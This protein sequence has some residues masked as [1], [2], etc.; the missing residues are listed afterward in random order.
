[1][2]QPPPRKGAYN[3]FVQNL[4]KDQFSKL[5]AKNQQE[6]DLLD[7]IRN[8]MKQRAAIEKLYA[9]GLIKLSSH[10]GS[11]KI[12]NLED[13]RVEGEAASPGEHNVYVIWKRMLEENE[14][15]AKARLAAIQVFQENISSDA[16]S[17]TTKK[18]SN[19]KKALDRLSAIQAEVQISISEVDRTKR[20]YFSEESDAIDMSKKAEDAELKAKGKKRDVMSIFQS[21]TTLKSKALK[22]SAKQDESDIKST[23]ARNDYLLAV[24]TANAHQD[25]YFHYDLQMTMRDMEYGIYEKMSEYFG[26]IARTELLTCTALQNS[27]NKLKDNAETMTRDYNYKC[28]TK[29]YGCLADHVQ[30][31]FESVEGDTIDHI[32]PSEHDD[33]YSLKYEA[34][35][36]AAKLNQAVKTIRA[37]RKR[38][39]ACEHHKAAGLLKEPNDANGPGLDDKIDELHAAIRAAETDLAKAKVR[40]K[41]LREGGVE[42]DS[43]LGDINLDTVQFDIEAEDKPKV[44]TTWDSSRTESQAETP[45]VSEDQNN[46]A[47]A[48]TEAGG[49]WATDGGWGEDAAPEEA[50][51]AQEDWAQAGGWEGQ[52]QQEGQWNGESAAL[53]SWGQ[54]QSVETVQEVAEAEAQPQAEIDPNADIWKAQVLFTF[55]SQNDD[56]LTVTE[57]EDVEILVRE[58]DEEGWVMARNVSGQKGYVPSNY[59]EVY[60]SVPKEETAQQYQPSYA[61]TEYTSYSRQGSLSSSG[62]VVKQVSVESTSSWGMPAPPAGMPPIP[63]TYGGQTETEA[64]ETEAETEDD[65][66]PPG[67]CTYLT[68]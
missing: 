61:A 22:L 52:Q 8:F 1:M 19:S 63:E 33:G 18:K 51:E 20:I 45:A 57:N 9:D 54:Q 62:Q 35:T 6:L 12:A 21:R 25:R 58:C 4:H 43:Y 16:K 47:A 11:K 42:V 40:L 48:P 55:T 66:M 49:D 37:F 60:A 30:Y 26:T 27:Y 56:E 24:E 5:Q 68:L 46:Y 64:S 59:I 53:D 44:A 28:Y 13:V 36:T 15:I 65:D 14:K 29:A 39:K 17:V 7:D 31:A 23:G 10:Y 32:T 2:A 41:K 67:Q 3:K 50:E 34:R 38:I